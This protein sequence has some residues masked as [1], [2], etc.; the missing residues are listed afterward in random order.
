MT[1]LVLA[2]RG[3]ILTPA[4]S[5][6]TLEPQPDQ[7]ESGCMLVKLK[8]IQKDEEGRIVTLRKEDDI[9]EL[10]LKVCDIVD[11]RISIGGNKQQ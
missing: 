3:P 4:K 8:P 5:S 9:T 7:P 1:R 11:L 2:K 6:P 10:G